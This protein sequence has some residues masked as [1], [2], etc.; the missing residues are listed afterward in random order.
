VGEEVWLLFILELGLDGV[1]DQ[2]H[3]PAALYT[4]GNGP[5]VPF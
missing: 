4:A 1:R 2:R 5:P 3:A